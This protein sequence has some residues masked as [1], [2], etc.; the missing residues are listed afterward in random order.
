MKKTIF[1]KVFSGYLF[2]TLILS[3][4]IL[5][6]AYIEIRHYYINTAAKEL[7]ELVRGLDLS[8]TPLFGKKEI[9]EYA[10]D[11]DRTLDKRITIITEDGTVMTDT[12]SDQSEM[13]NHKTRPEV[14]VALGGQ[15][16]TAV[17]FSKTLQMDMLYA[18]APIR[19][20][21]KI[22]GVLRVSR[23]LSSVSSLINTIEDKIIII[24][25]LC[26][27]AALAFGYGIFKRITVPIIEVRNNAKRFASGDF[28]ARVRSING[29][30]ETKDLAD[31]FNEMA[32]RIETLFT[33][34]NDRTEKLNRLIH[35][36]NEGLFVFSK[37]GRI[38]LANSSFKEIVKDDKCEGRYYWEYLRDS[39]F[40][41]LVSSARAGNTNSIQEYEFGGKTYIVSASFIEQSGDI[42]VVMSDIT[43][44]RSLE[45]I[46]KDFVANVSHELRT[47]LTAI[48]GFVETIE[49]D[50]SEANKRYIEIIKKHSDRLINIVADLLT[51][52]EL[53]EKNLSL[54]LTDVDLS[55][56]INDVVTLFQPRI[57]EKGLQ[58]KI[59]AAQDM[60]KVNGDIFRLEQLFINL[61]D[62]AVK[63]TE[64]GEIRIALNRANGNVLILI[65]DTG[66]G[67]P[68]EH[69]PRI[70]ERFYVADKGRSKKSGGTGLGLAIVKHI[71]MMHGGS[72]S[73]ESTLGVGT[74]FMVTLPIE[75]NNRT[76]S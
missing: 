2:L 35:S 12:R 31:A 59:S 9:A 4:L 26:I 70:F 3:G 71:A 52:S 7:T 61:I 24:T 42:V 39:Q 28:T 16:G 49:G 69:L 60:P 21:G 50:V 67:I 64:K 10:K 14:I 66:V 73:V 13:V 55:K 57:T 8:I 72:V 20:N 33:G 48:K 68:K 17:R 32:D 15:I 76:T 34:L 65:E 44:P 23:T 74:K 41:S 62:N 30:S 53:E 11:L 40:E 1:L 5:T 6:F 63:Y 54:E 29:P 46:K 27:I 75:Q 56:L 19:Q 51:L 43:V 47:P 22:V 18:A 58:V 37:D 38:T 25:L 36:L 45:K